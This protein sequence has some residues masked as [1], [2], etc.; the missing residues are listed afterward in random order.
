MPVPNEKLNEFLIDK[1]ARNGFEVKLGEFEISKTDKEYFMH[2]DN[3]ETKKSRKDIVS[4]SYE[5]ILT[6]TD[7]E[8]FKTAL[9]HG[10]GKKKAYGCGFLTIIPEK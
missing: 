4:A 10:I 6:I 8:K 7:L 5:G 1:A 9:I 3:G 2:T